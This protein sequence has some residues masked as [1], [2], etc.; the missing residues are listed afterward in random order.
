M[1]LSWEED[2]Q[3]PLLSPTSFDLL[4]NAFGSQDEAL[5]K[6]QEEGLH[7]ILEMKSC[8]SPVGTPFPLRQN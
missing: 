2:G 4:S 1:E 5:V 8:L 3:L 7:A 6:E